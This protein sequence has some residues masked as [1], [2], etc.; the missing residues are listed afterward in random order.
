MARISE[1]ELILPS[2][3]LIDINGGVLSTSE[4]IVKLRDLLKPTGKDVEIINGRNDD[5]FSQKVR[6]LKS[7]NTLTRDNLATYH[8]G[9]YEITPYGKNYLND[10]MDTI[11]YLFSN[12]FD[13]DDINVSLRKIEENKGKK[14][15]VFDE[16]VLV[17]EGVKSSKKTTIYNRSKEL[18][19]FAI[20]YYMSS[21]GN[22]PC[23]C[24]SFD[25]EKFYGDLGKGFI[26]MHH[27]KPVFKY[28]NDDMEKTLFDAVKNIVPVCS[29]CHRMIH[30]NR[31]EPISVEILV[32]KIKN[33][34]I[35]FV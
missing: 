21:S 9:R 29:N 7:H 13:Y 24:C 17:Y 3:L 33:Q 27:V 32:E 12:N 35:L 26:E 5:Y 8:D 31:K 14:I 2:L 23:V 25:F 20:Q 22:I 34:K 16:N 30:R 10:N 11:M 15:E 18:R 28:E 6:N 1:A 19:D 4:L